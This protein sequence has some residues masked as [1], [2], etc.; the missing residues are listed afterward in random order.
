L[1]K[2][3]KLKVVKQSK[4][5]QELENKCKK[6][7]EE[8]NNATYRMTSREEINL[9]NTKGYEEIGDIKEE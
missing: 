6:Y 5:I 9:M 8:I 1:T 2:I 3:L 4:I 7:E